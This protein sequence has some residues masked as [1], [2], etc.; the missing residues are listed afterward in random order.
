[1]PFRQDRRRCG[2]PQR[3]A[4]S[5]RPLPVLPF[6]KCTRHGVPPT[7]SVTRNDAVRCGVRS[8]NEPSRRGPTDAEPGSIRAGRRDVQALPSGVREAP[9]P[10]TASREM[11]NGPA[12]VLVGQR[13]AIQIVSAQQFR[14]IVAPR[15][16]WRGRGRG[17]RAPGVRARG[18]APERDRSEHSDSYAIYRVRR[19]VVGFTD[20]EL[21][22]RSRHGSPT[23]EVRNHSERREAR[24]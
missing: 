10:G 18:R 20:S 24:R 11:A 6:S 1:V 5:R 14:A 8:V 23:I 22:R 2:A 4:R 16:F 17:R 12:F 9:S 15:W 3:R 7:A 13:P 21:G 19:F